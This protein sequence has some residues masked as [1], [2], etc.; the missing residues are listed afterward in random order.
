V[1]R[2][3]DG[4][5][6]WRHA[7][8]T[9]ADD[10]AYGVVP[11]ADGGVLVAGYTK[12]DLD[13]AHAGTT[14]DD[15]FV[16]AVTADGE[17]AWTLQTG[18]PEAA[19]RFYAVAPDGAGGA[20]VAGYTSGAVGDTPS[21]GDKDA[22]LGRVS[23]DGDLLW[24]RQVGGAGEDKAL[25]V[26]A[27]PDGAVYVGGVSGGG[28][29]GVEH[30][31]AND[32][33][34][35]RYDADG[36]QEWLRAVATGENDQVSGLVVRSDGSVV[37]VGHTR[38][39]LGEGGALGDNDVVVRALDATGEV[40][41][42]TQVGTSTD[43]RGVTGVLGADDAVLVVG[44]T[45]GAMGSAVGGVDVV[46]VPVAADGTPGEATQ[47]GSRERDGAD[48][49]DDANLFAAPAPAADGREGAA[50]LTGLTYGAPAGT[51][52]AGA[53]D[54]FVAR[55]PWDAVVP[56]PS[57][58]GEPPLT[59][60]A[61]ARCLAGSAYVAVRATSTADAPV[62]VELATPYGT[63]VVTGV[64][65]GASAYQAFPVRAAEVPAGEATATAEGRTAVVPYDALACG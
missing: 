48:E 47:T 64:A 10:R 15:A 32:G 57:G 55:V 9:A 61:E 43:D 26:A 30:A 29:P 14:R 35:A 37:V 22:L 16:A 51:A 38:G 12:G 18:D 3:A 53:A 45:Y 34:I 60:T 4:A 62:D 17:R 23:A 44:T 52:N 49:W 6:V 7:V 63:R 11:G 39:A 31:G 33:W 40:L 54:V 41:W 27:S 58:P 59:V 36:E 19:D 25:A 21:A 8:A 42:T 5:E 28:M 50:L 20:Y 13:G 2:D 56:G 46:T 24:L 65:P 1:R